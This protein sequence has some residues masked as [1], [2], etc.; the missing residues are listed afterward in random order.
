MDRNIKTIINLR[1]FSIGVDIESIQRFKNLDRNRS[2]KFLSKIFTKKE[3][4]YCFSKNK[5]AE[6]L[7]ARFAGKEA[8][9]KALKSAGINASLI[10]LNKIEIN[11]NV[12]GV[13]VVSIYDD[14]FV[15][16][17][18]I[19]SLSHCESEAIAFVI[20]EKM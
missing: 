3:I 17:R 6:H 8:V 2:E 10:H 20:L 1:Y 16:I 14:K 9:L 5:P 13:P 11:K 12:E 4:N 19:L 7:A 18:I 15:K